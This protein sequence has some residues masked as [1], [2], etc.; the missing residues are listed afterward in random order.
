[1][2]F[3]GNVVSSN[4]LHLQLGGTIFSENIGH[5]SFEENSVTEFNDNLADFG[6]AIFSNYNSSVVF[7]DRSTVTFSNNR[8]HYCGVLTS[9]L[10]SSVTFTGNTNITYNRNVVSHT[11]PN[12]YESS[13]GGICTF[14]KSKTTFSENSSVAFI[15]NRADRGG[16][17]MIFDSNVFIEEYS[18]VTFYN[19]FA[20]F[21]S[22]GAFI[23]SNNSNVTIK[24]NSYVTFNGNKA[25]QDGGGMYSYDM[26]KI[27][28]TGN[29]TSTF[30]SNNARQNGGAV[31]SS[32]ASD[33]TFKGN[34]IVTFADNTADNGGAIYF[35]D[36][37]DI[38]FSDF[39]N[40][41]FRH[42][43]G[44]YGG[45]IS[46]NNNCDITLSG[47][48]NL[49]FIHNE[50]AQSG[51]AGYFNYS[52]NF[53]IQEN[54][55]VA[56]DNNKALHGGAVCI[57]S[58]TALIFKGNSAACF[59]NNLATVSGGAVNV[60]NDSS[61]T[62]Q[63]NATIKFVDNNAQYGGAIFLDTSATMVNNSDETCISFTNNIAKVLG[64][65]VYQ[66]ATEL[67]N[68]SCMVNR[69]VGVK[70]EYI[71]TPPNQLKFG[72]PAICIDDDYNTQCRSYY[73]RDIMLGTEIAIPACVLDYYN[74]S[75]D[76]TQFLV[77][78]K[79]HPI[80]INSGPKEA[81]IS[82]NKFDGVNII[83]NQSLSKSMNFSI[84]LTLNIAL[85]SNWKPILVRL[86]IELLPCRPGFWQY[87]NSVR[88][89][90]YNAS[91]IVFCSGSSST[92]KRDY[93][94]GNVTGKPTVTFCPINY[95][96]FTCC[97]TSNGYY[98]LSP[99]RDNQCRSHRSGTACGSCKE[100]YTLSF[101][102]PECVH[103]NECS[104][105]Q[106][107]LVLTLILLYWI[108]IIAAVFS[109]MHFKVAIGYLYAI[110]YYY[111]V[112]D[113][114]LSQNLYPSDTLSPMINV[115][116][117]IA[118]IIP[119][120]L[121]QFCFITNMSGIDQ[122]FIHYMHPVA[123]SL[124]LIMITVLAKRSHRLSSVIRK[125]IIHVICCLLLLSYTSVATTSLLL[126]RPL[127]FHD[128]DKV[129][130][131]V[132][133]DI[134]YF[135]GRHLAYAIV[136]VLFTIVIIIGLPLLL[137]LEPFLNSKINFIKIKPLLDQFQ[138]CYKDK[139]RYFA[140]YYMI[141]RLVIIIIVIGNSSNGI[142][143]QYSLI[144]ACVIMA[145]IHQIVKPYSSS[146][147]NN[148][149][150]TILHF[151]VLVSALPLAEISSTNNF[152]SNMLMGV[153]I[154]LIILPLLIFVTVSL[155]INKEKIKSLPGYCYIKCSQL[156]LRNYNEIP[157]NETEGLCHENDHE[158]FNVVDDDSR[159]NAT[160]CTV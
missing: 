103:V 28:F 109:I 95:C 92:I 124:F 135:H 137:G 142:I 71:A 70:N 68:S 118:K 155:I 64:N 33:I 46:A 112:V 32:Q 145:L 48:S 10:F 54:T 87:P 85:N 53:I 4:D 98:H 105:G 153:A 65:S 19:N 127:I 47:N 1:M 89:E 81:L 120:F 52:C 55:M 100:G 37:S 40:T 29:S 116:S 134:Q 76:S 75:V 143:L 16:A 23:C 136:A 128:V 25:S 133:P 86:I 24:D 41:T 63:K 158:F 62:V 140:A 79:I 26:C 123:I 5:V 12:N 43:I 66:D 151:L 104:L 122:Q 125:G 121:G 15:N 2:N 22:G 129:Y 49:L 111:S 99:V 74:H 149:D 94:F 27:I 84:N 126:M 117:S 96:N 50:A 144:T 102:S 113:L 80:F 57:K 147:L 154:V 6:T 69:A 78:S 14:K 101:D 30:S 31:I 82:C 139:Y 11:V 51:G 157:L 107:I 119:Q 58:E 39:T 56:L 45:A 115:M 9:A 13:A 114:L 130:T 7:K 61:V 90:C 132:S 72:D 59:C 106:T 20:W 131:Y 108:V 91:D 156:R 110:T 138:G 67:C 150:G 97:E 148:F 36:D 152:N 146:L 88:C 18:V 38:L 8:V 17:M 83:G 60:L 35:T 3:N 21:S 93:W 42:N 141:C 44:F 73:V 34:S 77:R 159:I 160:V